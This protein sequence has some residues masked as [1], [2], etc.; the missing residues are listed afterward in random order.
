MCWTVIV[1]RFFSIMDSPAHQ[2]DT[3]K[4]H[5]NDSPAHQHDS[6]KSQTNWSLY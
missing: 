1:V 6:E 4:S 5:S 3:E 2:H